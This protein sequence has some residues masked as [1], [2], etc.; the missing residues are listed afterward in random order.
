MKKIFLLSILFVIALTLK[1]QE[2]NQK[3]YIKLEFMH[4]MDHNNS[5]YLEVEEFWSEIHKQ[6]VADN[7]IVGW[8]LWQMSP[9]GSKQ[10]SQFFV[11]TLF[12]SLEAM[13]VEM[14]DGK[15]EDYLAQAHPNLSQA[16]IDKMMEK[17]VKSRDIAHEV[18][19]K[20]INTTRQEFDMPLGTIIVFDVMKQLHGSYEKV[21]NE[22]F[23]PW[24]QELVDKG[25]KE[26]WGLLKVLFPSGSSAEGTHLTFSMYKNHKQLADAMENWD[27]DMDM[28]TNLAV[29]KGLKT[30]DMVGVEKA[31]LVMKVR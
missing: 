16:E 8:D 19:C 18:Y 11:A 30:R 14:P 26:N 1:A 31:K 21:E 17:T 20:Q 24:H 22:I 29:Q 13:L 12:T 15:F 23:K 9:G 5:D 7:N 6:R 28:K 10:G 25:K 27:G 2:D 3:L 4:V